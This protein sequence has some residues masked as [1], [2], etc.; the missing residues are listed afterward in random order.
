MLC[1]GAVWLLGSWQTKKAEIAEEGYNRFVSALPAAWPANA[2]GETT[3]M[4]RFRKIFDRRWSLYRSLALSAMVAFQ[5]FAMLQ[6]ACIWLPTSALVLY[7]IHSM[8]TAQIIALA[9]VLPRLTE[10]LLDVSN[11]VSNIGDYLGLKGRTAWLKGALANEPVDLQAHVD[12]SRI[13]LL[14]KVDHD[15]V[16]VDLA[17][18]T[19]LVRHAGSIGRY[20]LLGPN[21]SGKTSFLLRLKTLN[22]GS[23]FYLPALS[24]LFPEFGHERSTGESKSKELFEAMKIAERENRVLLLDEWDANLDRSNRALISAL[25]DKLAQTHVVIEVT[26]SSHPARTA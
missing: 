15:W 20:A 21:G 19:D 17:S 11:L 25:L 14:R 26:H 24:R 18:A 7:R 6:A 16:E 3:V 4:N 5:S 12:E 10:T 8:D 9:I 23:V 1:W 22:M 13:R 2:L